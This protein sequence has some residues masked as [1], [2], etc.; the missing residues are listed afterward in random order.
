MIPEKIDKLSTK[1]LSQILPPVRHKRIP[2]HR[3]PVQSKAIQERA[4]EIVK[5]SPYGRHINPDNQS[6]GF[7]A[8]VGSSSEFR[9]LTVDPR[10][11]QQDKQQGL[12]QVGAQSRRSRP[13]SNASFMSKSSGISKYTGFTAFTSPEKR[14]SKALAEAADYKQAVTN[15]VN[16]LAKEEQKFLKKIQ[17]TRLESAKRAAIKED[18]IKALQDKLDY[19]K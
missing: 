15:R 2:T 18:K 17:K 5:Q 16:Y 6:G 10:L 1:E 12:D 3:E 14:A 4:K 7:S 13:I 9:K 8:I 11:A 19:E